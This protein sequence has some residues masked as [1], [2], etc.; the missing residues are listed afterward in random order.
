MT[1]LFT[2][3]TDRLSANSSDRWLVIQSVGRQ[4]NW[5]MFFLLFSDIIFILYDT[6]KISMQLSISLSL[7]LCLFV[8]V[9]LSLPPSLSLSPLP[10]FTLF[11]LPCSLSSLFDVLWNY[12][13]VCSFSLHLHL[14]DQTLSHCC[15]GWKK[16]LKKSVYKLFKTMKCVH[17]E[18]SKEKKK[19]CWKTKRKKILK[20]LL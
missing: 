6:D 16:L 17:G 20:Q 12:K 8:S 4:L 10:I 9:S 7:S 2:F 15:Q 19:L 13:K 18:K 11:F 3:T 1:A 14:R 5:P